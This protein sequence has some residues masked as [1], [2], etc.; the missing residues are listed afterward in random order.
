MPTDDAA[1]TAEPRRPLL[2]AI[3]A[4]GIATMLLA[5]PALSGGFLVTHHSDQYIAGYAFREFA[6]QSLRAGNGFPLWNPYLFGGMPY[7][8]A[9]HGDI[10]Y[11]TF[12][13]RMFLPT[14][15]AMTW[16]FIIHL[17]LCGIFAFLFLRRIGIG[18]HASLVGALAY[19]LS[20]QIASLVS[21]GHDGKLF[22]STLFPLTLLLLHHGIRGAR[23]WA[24]GALAIVVGLAVLSPHPQLLQYML[25]AS[26]AYALHLAYFGPKDQRLPRAEG[27]RRLALALVAIV[28]GMAIGAVQYLPV[29]Q[30]V[31]W[32][33]RSGGMLGGYEHAVSYSMPVP[34]LLF[35]TIIPQFTGILDQYWGENGIHLH[36]EYLGIVPVVLASAAFGAEG[37]RR[38]RVAWFWAVMCIVSALWALG[39]NTGFY[40]LVY[41][42]VPGTRFFRAP[43]TI[44]YI[45]AFSVAVLAALGTERLLARAISRRFLIAWATVAGIIALL[46]ISGALTNLAHSFA[47][48]QRYELVENNA[49]ALRLG[50]LRVVL[51][52]AAGL[53][54]LWAIMLGKLSSTRGGWLVAAVVAADLWSIDRIYWKFS[55]PA[56]QTFASDAT[57]DYLKK[58]PQPGRV[59]TLI[60]RE[61]VRDPFIRGDAL[62]GHGVRNVLGYHGNQLGRY[63]VLMGGREVWTNLYSNPNVWRLTNIRY[64]LGSSAEP[65]IQGA[66]LVAG[67]ARNAYGTMVYLHELPMDNPFAW[68]TP[69]LVKAGD[70]QVLPTLLDPRFDL[71]TVALFDTTI[72]AAGAQLTAVPEPL[73]ITASV[74]RYEPGKIALTLDSAAPAGSAL[75]VSENFYP[76][77]RATVDGKSALIGRADFVLTGVALP[78]GARNIELSFENPAYERGKLVT[79][80]ALGA[81]V[82]LLAAGVVVERRQRASG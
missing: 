37:P 80:L 13:L 51:F 15:V 73:P 75:V 60:T 26:G 81:A 7:V 18:F 71:R 39:G 67:P 66:R 65:P 35:N 16:G 21:P 31:P 79:L 48:A 45:S 40:R 43:S 36:S 32:S 11:P 59:L 23:M 12:L 28:L 63:D 30:Y 1:I 49:S 58:Q 42:L 70:D 6:A 53:G 3:L 19:M 78:A 72:A 52:A 10:F 50:A 62:M 56:A 61:T 74:T 24:W 57:I 69:A 8:D 20:G 68:V 44:F 46:G 38:K 29:M 27:T 55:P 14:D 9:M 34:E 5:Y 41:A 2:W 82:L 47:D 54:V 33:A 64:L 25:L 76:G 22:V 17:L 77:W 4:C